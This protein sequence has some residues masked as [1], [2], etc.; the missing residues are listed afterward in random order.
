LR[1]RF[2]I[3][4]GGGLV[5]WGVVSLLAAVFKV[6]LGK[7]CFPVFLILV[8]IYL[9]FRPRLFLG[10]SDLKIN[11]FPHIRRSGAWTLQSEDIAIFV[12][13][14]KLDL[15]QAEIPTGETYLRVFGFV[16]DL[17]LIAPPDVGLAVTSVAFLTSARINGQKQDYFVS[18][19]EWQSDNYALAE[20]KVHLETG[21]FVN[22]LN[23]KQYEV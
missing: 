20:R 7:Y 6:D 8:G 14:V 19:M 2:L 4:V 9:I 22:D 3:I 1:N 21:L 12:G 11:L 17:D 10:D 13:D 18:A 15:S 5:L 23:I 16:C